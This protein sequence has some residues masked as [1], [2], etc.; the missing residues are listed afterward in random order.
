MRFPM[1]GLMLMLAGCASSPGGEARVLAIEPQNE[2]GVV[3]NVA[4]TSSGEGRTVVQIDVDPAGHPDMPA[5]I[6]SGTCVE[7]IPQPVYPL[8]NVRDG[9]S[10][11]EIPVALS[12]LLADP[13]VVN[14]HHSN[15]RME[16]STACVRLGA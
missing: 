16:I 3:G 14:L 10:R 1:I 15:D 5:H 8:E 12:E 6:H 2:S 4:L 9:T 7:M 11:T 13:V